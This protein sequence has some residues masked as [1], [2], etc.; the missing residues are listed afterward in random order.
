M[1]TF[2]FIDMGLEDFIRTDNGEVLKKIFSSYDAAEYW[3]EEG[4][5]DEYG[6]TNQGTRKWCWDEQKDGVDVP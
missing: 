5:L 1:Y 3:I 4:G 6:W 2:S